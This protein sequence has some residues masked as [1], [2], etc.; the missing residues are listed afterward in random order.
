MI[1]LI[2]AARLPAAR[3]TLDELIYK[4]RRPFNR[5]ASASM[6]RKHIRTHFCFPTV[7]IDESYLRYLEEVEAANPRGGAAMRVRSCD[8]DAF[9]TSIEDELH[10]RLARPGYSPVTSTAAEGRDAA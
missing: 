4:G 8:F 3:P 2:A 9:V 10:S 5:R 7:T 1:S 6:L